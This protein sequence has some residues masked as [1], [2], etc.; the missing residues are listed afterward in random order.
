MRHPT[1]AD[2]IAQIG[3]PQAHRA[4]VLRASTASLAYRPERATNSNAVLIPCGKPGVRI[5]GTMGF[6]ITAFAIVLSL[7]PTGD[8]TNTMGFE[9]KVAGGTVAAILIGLGLYWRGSRQSSSAS[10]VR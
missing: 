4:P 2:P 10:S 7:V 8:I 6:G 5:A 3:A 1:S 9:L